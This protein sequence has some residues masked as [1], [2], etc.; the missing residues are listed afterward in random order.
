MSSLNTPNAGNPVH[1]ILQHLVLSSHALE[2]ICV[3]HDYKFSSAIHDF[4]CAAVG[5]VLFE[6]R[7]QFIFQQG[8][9]SGSYNEELVC[10]FSP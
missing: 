3:K 2:N 6:M 8:I 10:T 4:T 5:Q 7:I 1:V 9:N